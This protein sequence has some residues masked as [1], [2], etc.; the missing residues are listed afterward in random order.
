[1]AEIAFTEDDAV[2]ILSCHDSLLHGSQHGVC[3]LLE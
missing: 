2:R 1:V 3:C